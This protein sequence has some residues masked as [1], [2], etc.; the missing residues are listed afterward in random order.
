M[1][2]IDLNP[3]KKII[4]TVDCFFISSSKSMQLLNIIQLFDMIALTYSNN[5]L[6]VSMN[7]IQ[8]KIT[9]YFPFAAFYYAFVPKYFSPEL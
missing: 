8:N 9:L 2:I 7:I 3:I 6:N 1:H 4:S 5:Q